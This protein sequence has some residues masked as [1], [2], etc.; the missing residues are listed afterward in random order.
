MRC[1]AS[2]LAVSLL[3]HSFGAEAWAADL[4]NNPTGGTHLF[5]FSNDKT[6]GTLTSPTTP[7]RPTGGGT[8]SGPG[9]TIPSGPNTP[10]TQGGG[11]GGG[12]IG[13]G[14]PGGGTTG[15]GGIPGGGS[16]GGGTLP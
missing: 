13:G 2:I 8:S 11:P 16:P 9:P 4:R 12:V 10:P 15:G 5:V 1:L 6:G 14:T 7:P 3:C